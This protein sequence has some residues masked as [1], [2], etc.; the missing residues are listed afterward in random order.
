MHINN[1]EHPMTQVAGTFDNAAAANQAIA[2]LLTAGLT[3][4]DISLIM[5]DKAK[6]NFSA[7]SK[8]TGD[9]TVVDTA[10]G[11]GT[12]GVLGAL[13]AG[14]TATGAVLIPGAQLL[15]VG[16]LVSILAGVGTGAAVGGLAGALSAVGISAAESS[17]YVDE[18]KAGKAVVLAHTKD[19]EQARLVRSVLMSE[20]ADEIK[21]A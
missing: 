1:G 4:D 2:S 15:V 18:I 14:L 20:G 8:D 7:A 19:D 17:R 16:P 12:G 21:A 11:A 10:I 6:R 5:S 9:R 3:K 13:L